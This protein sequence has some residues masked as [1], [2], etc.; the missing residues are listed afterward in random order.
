MSKTTTKPGEGTLSNVVRID[1]EP[2]QEHLGKIVRGSVEDTLNGQCQIK[3]AFDAFLPL[4]Y[5]L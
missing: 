3:K 2:I 5:F 4:P 1:D